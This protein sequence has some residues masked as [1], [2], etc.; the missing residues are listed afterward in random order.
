MAAAHYKGSSKETISLT[1]EQ[2]QASL[3]QNLQLDMLQQQATW[4]VKREQKDSSQSL[5]ETTYFAFLYGYPITFIP[6]E[7]LGNLNKKLQLICSCTQGS[8]LTVPVWSED[9][10]H[11][12]CV[13]IHLEIKNW[14]MC[15]SGRF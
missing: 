8:Q 2:M 12:R 4:A 3:Q 9:S 14:K 7:V 5:A 15:S 10:L 13:G 11:F 6:Q 1:Q